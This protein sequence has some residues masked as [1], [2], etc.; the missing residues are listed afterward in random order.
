MREGRLLDI[1]CPAPSTRYHGISSATSE[2]EDHGRASEELLCR[3]IANVPRKALLNVAL[4]D[5]KLSR[6]ATPLIYAKC[7]FNNHTRE[8]RLRS[9]GC[10][11]RTLVS[12]PGLRSLT[13]KLRTGDW[14][15][16]DPFANMSGAPPMSLAELGE[17]VS[18]TPAL[19]SYPPDFQR[20]LGNGLLN[21]WQDAITVAILCLLPNL[22]SI[23]LELDY[24]G[25]RRDEPDTQLTSFKDFNGTLTINFI[26]Q[27]TNPSI[28]RL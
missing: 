9:L 19:N 6:I 20:Q 14:K 5:R 28:A 22:S 4:V 8:G 24:R 23:V 27:A 18:C 21:L 17:L 26:E 1:D 15:M 25:R 13:W 11:L 7:K 12:N 3:I 2:H 10:L 16:S